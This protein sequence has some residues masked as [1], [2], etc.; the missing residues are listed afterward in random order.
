M[1]KNSPAS[2][3]PSSEA[4]L[5]FCKN[6]G[7]PENDVKKYIHEV[8]S[9]LRDI[10]EASLRFIY[11]TGSSSASSVE[12][13]ERLVKLK[14]VK[15]FHRASKRQEAVVTMRD[16]PGGRLNLLDELTVLANLATTGTEATFRRTT[17]RLYTLT[18]CP[19][20]CEKLV[21]QL[22]A[23]WYSGSA[24]TAVDRCACGLSRCTG[25]YG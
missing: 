21:L 15:A 6:G 9:I 17:T 3:P 18:L 13:D 8:W 5:F 14:D 7:P 19:N 4:H 2:N 20:R 22:E 23:T 11:A 16:Q 1:L 24:E 10:R 12:L 25:D